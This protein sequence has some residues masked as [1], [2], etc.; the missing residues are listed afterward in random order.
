M[1]RRPMIQVLFL[2]LTIV[3]HRLKMRD[4]RTVS[5]PTLLTRLFFETKSYQHCNHLPFFANTFSNTVHPSFKTAL[6]VPVNH[7]FLYSAH[8][9]WNQRIANRLIRTLIKLKAPNI[10]RFSLLIEIQRLT[11]I[12]SKTVYFTTKVFHRIT[13]LLALFVLVLQTLTFKNWL[14]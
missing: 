5:C 6:V 4:E 12:K 13:V 8:F 7:V 1:H 10:T 11:R 9:H 14:F 3:Q 2:T